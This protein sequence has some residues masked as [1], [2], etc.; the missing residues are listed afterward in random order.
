MVHEICSS[1]RS[2]KRKSTASCVKT[3]THTH[4]LVCSLEAKRLEADVTSSKK[5]NGEKVYFLNDN[6]CT[7]LERKSVP[8]F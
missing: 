8:Y 6:A 5:T 4:K 2:F 7:Q 1:V 3:H